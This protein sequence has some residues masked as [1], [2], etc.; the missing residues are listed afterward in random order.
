VNETSRGAA[1]KRKIVQSFLWIFV[2]VLGTEFYAKAP[3]PIAGFKNFEI[4]ESAPVETTMDNW[5]KS[6]F[7]NASLP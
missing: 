2:L 7:H 6:Y 3:T 5:E 4:V 1:M